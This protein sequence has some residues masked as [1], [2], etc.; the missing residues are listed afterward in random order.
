MTRIIK[1]APTLETE[2]LILRAH[3]S[4]DFQDCADMWADPR[5]TEYISGTPSTREQSWSRLLRYAGHWQHMGFG[6]WVVQRKSD[7]RYVGEAGFADYKRD[8]SPSIEGEPEA[9]WVLRSDAH[10]KGYATEVVARML[11]WADAELSSEKT[12]CIVD[13]SH[14]GSIN[15]AKKNG[16]GNE[17][18]GLYGEHKTLFLQRLRFAVLERSD[19]SIK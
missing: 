13:P 4:D 8:T 1:S 17:Q 15:V 19:E 11:Q 18:L 6:Y 16:Y 12:V 2:R 7:G 10:G 14:S 5:V 3:R 9:G